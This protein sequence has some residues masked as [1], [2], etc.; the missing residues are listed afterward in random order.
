MNSKELSEL[1]YPSLAHTPD[2]YEAMYPQR[3][4]PEGAMVTRLGPSPTGF[5]HLGNLYGA[6]VDE[7]LAHQSGGTFFLRIED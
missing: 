6:F 2:D 4:L 3:D 5:I 1:I 7:R